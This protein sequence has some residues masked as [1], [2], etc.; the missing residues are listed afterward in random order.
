VNLTGRRARLALDAGTN[1]MWLKIKVW[2][3]VVLFVVLAL[4]GLLFIFKNSD[5]TVKFWYW[6]NRNPET[7]ALVL[8]LGSFICGVIVTI[9]LRTT[10][11]TLRQIRELQARTRAE[12]LTR[13]VE[14]MKTKA[15]MLRTRET[16]ATEGAPGFP[17]TPTDPTA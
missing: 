16:A 17:V 9:L 2:T 7:P 8:V 5:A 6:F 10:F 13:E 3:K 15:A 4:Y 14:A 11:K 1:G 12:R